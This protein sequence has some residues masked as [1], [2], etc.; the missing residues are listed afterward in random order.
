MGSVVCTVGAKIIHL[1]EMTRLALCFA[2]Y[3]ILSLSFIVLGILMI[4]VIWKAKYNN[5]THAINITLILKAR[6]ILETRF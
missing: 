2:T 1:S 6:N 3:N 4:R 5:K